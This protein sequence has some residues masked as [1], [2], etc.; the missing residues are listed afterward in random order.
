MTEHLS[1][2]LIIVGHRGL[3]LLRDVSFYAMFVLARV[4]MATNAILDCSTGC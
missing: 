3:G 4:V 1:V 2:V